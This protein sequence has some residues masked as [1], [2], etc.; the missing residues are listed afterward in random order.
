MYCEACAWLWASMR[1]VLMGIKGSNTTG[2]LGTA[3]WARQSGAAESRVWLLLAAVLSQWL[4]V[5][6]LAGSARKLANSGPLLNSSKSASRLA[7]QEVRTERD[8]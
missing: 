7:R 5:A 4:A 3:Q 6:G 8:I 2:A 1:G